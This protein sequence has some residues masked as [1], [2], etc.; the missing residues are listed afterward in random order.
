MYR[1]MFVRWTTFIT[2]D[3]RN[4][5]NEKLV[6]TMMTLVVLLLNR[7]FAKDSLELDYR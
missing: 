5:V 2:D 3:V 4:Y 7:N 6:D 1:S